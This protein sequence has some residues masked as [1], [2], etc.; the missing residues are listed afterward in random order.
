MSNF[1]SIVVVDRPHLGRGRR[2]PPNSLFHE[3]VKLRENNTKLKREYKPRARLEGTIN[4]V[5]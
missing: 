1:V 2:V 4:Y 5:T 3:S